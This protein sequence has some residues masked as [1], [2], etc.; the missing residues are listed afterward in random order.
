VFLEEL[1]SGKIFASSARNIKKEN[2]KGWQKR[3][4][5]LIVQGYEIE[6]FTRSKILK[7]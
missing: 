5:K 1:K 7:T 3:L 2:V 4:Q 6:V